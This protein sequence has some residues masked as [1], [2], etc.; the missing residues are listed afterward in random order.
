MTSSDLEPPHGLNPNPFD[1]LGLPAPDLTDEKEVRAAEERP[2]LPPTWTGATARMSPGTRPPL[3]HTSSC[4]RRGTTVKPSPT[5]ASGR[6][7][8]SAAER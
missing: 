4:I 7:H 1:A 2:S 5:W 3:R 8:L 6:R